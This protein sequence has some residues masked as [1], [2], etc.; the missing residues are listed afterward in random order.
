MVGLEEKRLTFAGWANAIGA[1]FILVECVKTGV[2]RLYEWSY[3]TRQTN[4]E[5]ERI[6]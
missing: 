4:E 2:P 6:I 3:K 1:K 5:G